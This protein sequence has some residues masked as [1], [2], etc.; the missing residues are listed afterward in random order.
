[1]NF[2]V[3]IPDD[4]R[5]R[6]LMSGFNLASSERNSWGIELLEEACGKFCIMIR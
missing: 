2:E 5:Q 6:K 4:L 3:S 1:M